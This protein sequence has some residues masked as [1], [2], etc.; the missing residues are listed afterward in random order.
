MIGYIV[1]KTVLITGANRGLGLEF[2]KQYV[3]SNWKVIATCRKK[4]DLEATKRLGDNVSIFE[5][6]VTNFEECKSI[7]EILKDQSIDV[8]I[9]NAGIFGP[10]EQFYNNINKL[11]E[12]G[13][14]ETYLVNVISPIRIAKL[15]VDNL[16]KSERKLA[17]FITSKMGSISDNKS[18]GYYNYRASKAA[19]NTMVKSFSIDTKEIYTLLLHPG[20]VKTDMGGQEANISPKESIQGMRMVIENFTSDQNGMFYDYKGRPILW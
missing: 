19:L 9:N 5:M 18:G 15:F 4:S 7:R 20:W 14:L 16:S 12:R 11:D 1:M 10:E 6:D 8:L 13:W 3:D 2:V 17:V